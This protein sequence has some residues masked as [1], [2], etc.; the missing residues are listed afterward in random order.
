[1]IQIIRPK[2]SEY[3][4]DTESDDEINNDD[5]K[6]K[7]GTNSF[8]RTVAI[9]RYGMRLLGFWPQDRQLLYHLQCG[10]MFALIVFVYFP[11]VMQMCIMIYN[12]TD[13]N[14]VMHQSLDTILL[15]VLLSRFIFMKVMAKNFRIVLH[16]MTIDWKDYR[17]LTKR[18]QRIMVYYARKGRGFSILS[19]ALMTLAGIGE[20][21]D[22][23]VIPIIKF[24]LE[25]IFNPCQNLNSRS[26]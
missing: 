24:N 7:G 9:T 1:M 15:T 17:Y 2:P 26:I 14:A 20:K 18:N 8:D 25:T 22:N 12:V 23:Q 11:A 10:T 19:T 21:S 3:D 16:A 4:G 6:K 13:W 5:N